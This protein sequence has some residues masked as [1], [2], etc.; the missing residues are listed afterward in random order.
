MHVWVKVPAGDNTW[1]TNADLEWKFDTIKTIDKIRYAPVTGQAHVEYARM[2]KQSGC[3]A[4]KNYVDLTPELLNEQTEPVYLA[5][6]L[7]LSCDLKLVDAT[8]GEP[9]T[10][11]ILRS[12]VCPKVSGRI[13]DGEGLLMLRTHKPRVDETAEA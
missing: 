2:P 4:Y 11:D 13:G 7:S 1:H 9:V 6:R 8:T 3:T 10:L 5:A 12:A